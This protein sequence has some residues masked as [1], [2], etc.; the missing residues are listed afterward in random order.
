[1]ETVSIDIEGW[2]C[3]ARKVN[4]DALLD[5]LIEHQDAIRKMIQNMKKAFVE[6]TREDN[7]RIVVTVVMKN[8]VEMTFSLLADAIDEDEE[9]EDWD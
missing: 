3:P 8:E 4:M 6:L 2:S 7:G 5:Y 9:D 1:M